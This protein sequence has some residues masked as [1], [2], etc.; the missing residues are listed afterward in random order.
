MSK[1]FFY[2][3]NTFRKLVSGLKLREIYY[4]KLWRNLPNK[5]PLLILFGQKSV[6]QYLPFLLITLTLLLSL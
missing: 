6:S 3:H 5:Y 1:F 4:K 2:I